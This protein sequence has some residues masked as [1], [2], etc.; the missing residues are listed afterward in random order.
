ML[1]DKSKDTEAPDSVSDGVF[2]PWCAR[3]NDRPAVGGGGGARLSNDVRSLSLSSVLLVSLGGF[4]GSFCS[5]SGSQPP[6]LSS[7]PKSQS[8]AP[9][10][11]WG[12]PP[13][14]CFG[15]MPAPPAVVSSCS[16]LPASVDGACTC[17]LS[18]Q[19]GPPG[20][21]AP[22]AGDRP[23]DHPMAG[24]AQHEDVFEV[25]LDDIQPA[26]VES[27]VATTVYRTK[28]GYHAIGA[29][30]P[31]RLFVTVCRGCFAGISATALVLAAV[32]H[33]RSPSGAHPAAASAASATEGRPLPLAHSPTFA[34]ASS[35]STDP[36]QR[37]PSPPPLPPTYPP[38]PPPMPTRELVSD[39]SA[40]V[41]VALGLLR[42]DPP[43]PPP[44]LPPPATP[45]PRPPGPPRPPP[46]DSYRIVKAL[47]DRFVDWEATSDVSHAGVL[48]RLLD[49][50]NDPDQPWRPCRQPH[51]CAP[52]GDRLPAAMLNARAHFLYSKP[53]AGS[54]GFIA[55]PESARVLCAY[56]ADGSTMSKLCDG[57]SD[58]CVPGCGPRWCESRRSY[59]CAFPGSQ[60]DQ[61]LLMQREHGAG[62][63]GLQAALGYNE[64]VLDAGAWSASLPASVEAIF[65][66]DRASGAEVEA[67][68]RLHASFHAA[69]A[70]QLDPHAAP[71]VRYSTPRSYA[72]RGRPA[73]FSLVASPP[74]PPSPPPPSPP[75]PSPSPSPVAPSPP[76]SPPS[77]PARAFTLADLE[78]PDA[79][80]RAVQAMALPGAGGQSAPGGG[81][82]AVAPYTPPFEYTHNPFCTSHWCSSGCA[83]CGASACARSAKLLY[84]HTE[85]TG[86]SSVEC[87]TQQTLVKAGLWVNLG[88]N[89]LANAQ[90]C[91]ESCS[92]QQSAIVLSVR[93]PYSYWAS[94]YDYA[95]SGV[96]TSVRASANDLRSMDAFLAWVRSHRFV[97]Q[98]A[99]LQRACG[100]PCAYDALLRT[101]TLEQDWQRLLA[102]LGV[103]PIAL[104]RR[105]T[106]GDPD[107][108]SSPA[109]SRAQL[110]QI[111]ELDAWVFSEFGYEQR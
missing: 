1:V 88:H 59:N 44:P 101:E 37:P 105:N 80:R 29:A 58:G 67:A 107:H 63:L 74:P 100:N 2:E 9:R 73:P 39:I 14:V 65:Y 90:R 93:E 40:A 95:K 89:S 45:P 34:R 38:P 75:P 52:Y 99:R 109:L 5:C 102:G 12:S 48:A 7:I 31:G 50:S 77:A 86:G 27:L 3:G 30:Q 108:H 55:A 85:K 64:I 97:T 43:M 78:D 4:E 54:V 21:R 51:W 56:S 87:A 111:N 94:V 20:R 11:R 26:V 10:G 49:P 8:R 79:W 60:L 96:A 91:F 42:S 81:A 61:A 36:S 68:R 66:S 76:P 70:G 104:P 69:Y 57:G 47:N 22:S 6:R 23:R 18:P 35:P 41:A 25:E 71:L 92:G 15:C 17:C 62:K 98:T 19:P 16:L 33:A 110:D 13:L 46:P 28:S 72:D 106:N 82:G 103:P 24:S 32:L 83:G 84:L 53:G